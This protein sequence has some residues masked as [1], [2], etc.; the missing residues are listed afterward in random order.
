MGSSFKIR[1]LQHEDY[2][3]ILK[4]SKEIWDGEDYLPRVYHQWVD[5]PGLFLGVE[6]TLSHAVV[7]VAHV[8]LL[9]DGSAWLEGLRVRTD[10]RGKGLSRMIMKKQMDYALEK[11]KEGSIER[12]ASTTYI[13]NEVSMHL[14]RS[15][16]FKLQQTNLILSWNPE[17][18]MDNSISIDPWNPTFSEI[19]SLPYF[20]DT[21]DHIIQ[22]FMVQKISNPWWEKSKTEFQF[23]KVNGSRGWLD[24]NH[25]PHC[26][27]LEPTKDSLIDW[28]MYASFRFDKEASTIIFPKPSLILELK[29]TKLKT[30]SDWVPDCYYFVYDPSSGNEI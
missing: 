8:A 18:G 27:V 1:T 9:P 7:A 22:F 12:I 25:E 5:S 24:F 21:G 17:E 11:L 29:E 15:S 23:F 2:P 6:D 20:Q 4:I 16:G 28:L 14:S 3:D 19:K 13:D 10:F 30:W 26:V